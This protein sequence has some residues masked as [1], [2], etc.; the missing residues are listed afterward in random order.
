M[1]Y[2]PGDHLHRFYHVVKRIVDGRR[3]I[4]FPETL[5]NWHSPRGYVENV[6]EAIALAATDERATRRI[7]NVC[8][9]PSFSELEWA[10]K[11]A[12]EMGW[13]GEFGSL[14]SR[15][16]AAPSAEARKCRAALER[17]FRAH[18]PRTGVQRSG[19]D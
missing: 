17:K 1:V 8:E 18:S 19:R 15:T 14:A 6:A 11:I 9:Q 10:T 7:Y 5:A 4:I 2:G 3:Q 12:A 16:H 13:D